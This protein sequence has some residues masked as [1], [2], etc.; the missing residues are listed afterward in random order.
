MLHLSKFIL[1]ILDLLIAVFVKF[2]P[3]CVLL[4]QSFDVLFLLTDGNVALIEEDIILRNFFPKRSDFFIEL[5]YAIFEFCL[6]VL[7]KLVVLLRQ[8]FKID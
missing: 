1:Q 8:F 5:D 6:V 3:Q 7:Q 4:Q 2:A